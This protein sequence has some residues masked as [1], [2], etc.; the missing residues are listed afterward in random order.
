MAQK[1]CW[2]FFCFCRFKKFERKNETKFEFEDI[3]H[4][5]LRSTTLHQKF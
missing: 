5:A 1:W 3:G 4:I 2:G